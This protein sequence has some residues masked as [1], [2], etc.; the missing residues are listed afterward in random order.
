[1]EKNSIWILIFLFSI[2]VI[3]SILTYIEDNIAILVVS[4]LYLIFGV[5]CSFISNESEH[6]RNLI[7]IFLLFFLIYLIHSVIIYYGIIEVYGSPFIKSDELFFSEVSDTVALKFKLGYT[8]F[9]L[10]KIYI[11]GT[12]GVYFF[13]LVS[14][15][16]N[17]FEENSVLILKISVVFISALIPMYLYGISR[18]YFSENLSIWVATIYGFFSFVPYLSSTLLRDTHIALM[19]IITMY[20]ILQKLSIVNFIILIFAFFTSYYLRPQTGLFMMGFSVIYFF[21]FVRSM[22]SNRY[23]ELLIYLILIGIIVIGVLNSNLMEV[24]D[25]TANSS[26]NKPSETQ[27]SGMGAKIAKL[28]IPINIIAQ[29]SYGQMQP[30]PPSWIFTG[31]N[32]GLFQISYLIAGIAWFLGWGFLLYGLF[33]KKILSKIDFKLNLMFFISMLYLI[34]IATIITST[35][36]QMPVYPILYLFMVFSYLEMSI[37][38][39]TKIWVGMSLFY[40]T[41]VLVI[42]FLKI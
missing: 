39:R 12:A 7:Y 21:L 29:F 16:A 14:T 15:L 26:G 37:T 27:A 6:I 41:L 13:G 40:I 9:E 1:M 28:P 8:F 36:R 33:K 11:E 20:I 42:N 3:L 2:L 32:K 19:F 38:E 24:Y 35:R 25:M 22:V 31:D 18:L 23:I 10:D 4:I 34:L 30:F 5:L 17:L